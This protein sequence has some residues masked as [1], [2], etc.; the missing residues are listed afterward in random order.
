MSENRETIKQKKDKNRKHIDD[1]AK[2][3]ALNR[4]IASFDFRSDA[5]EKVSNEIFA[6]LRCR[7][8]WESMGLSED[9]PEELT[10]DHLKELVKQKKPRN[11]LVVGAGVSK[12][13]YNIKAADE[14]IEYI[15]ESLGLDKDLRLLSE[16]DKPST[17]FKKDVKELMT[18]LEKIKFGNEGGKPNSTKIESFI[19]SFSKKY[20]D[21]KERLKRLNPSVVSSKSNGKRQKLDEKLDFELNLSL[22]ASHFG[23]RTV[24]EKIREIYDHRYYPCMIYE[25]IAHLLRHRFLDA[26]INFNFDELLDQ[27][28]EEEI[29]GGDH[30]YILSD[31]D[32]G[33]IG[34]LIIK[35]A[36]N[37]PLYIKPHGTVSHKSTM[38]FTKDDYLGISRD[39][40]NFLEEFIS[41]KINSEGDSIGIAKVNIILVGFEMASVE[42]NQIIEKS[43]KHA[44][45]SRDGKK[46]EF[47][48][49]VF[50]YQDVKRGHKAE[51]LRGKIEEEISSRLKLR[52]DPTD[53]FS[54]YTG[55]RFPT[56]KEHFSDLYESTRKLFSQTY[57]PSGIWRKKIVCSL[58]HREDLLPSRM[59]YKPVSI[60]ED[61]KA[62]KRIKK[63]RDQD[64]FKQR[65][66]VEILIELA[67]HKGS[68]HTHKLM[69]GR[70]GLYH[71]LY[72]KVSGSNESLIDFIHSLN[73]TKCNIYSRGVYVDKYIKNFLDPDLTSNYDLKIVDMLLMS[74]QWI[75]MKLKKHCPALVKSSGVD[76]YYL[77]EN[78]FEL[79]KRSNY[80]ISPEY[81]AKRFTL[82]PGFKKD[83]ILNT[84][85]A[86]RTHLNTMLKYDNWDK[87][88]SVG[89]RGNLLFEDL[90]GNQ[91]LAINSNKNDPEKDI[92][93]ILTD[94]IFH[95]SFLKAKIPAKNIGYIPY[96]GRDFCM[97]FTM[98]AMPEKVKRE[99]NEPWIDENKTYPSTLA[100]SGWVV[101]KAI[102]FA[103]NRSSSIITPVFLNFS[104]KLPTPD[105]RNLQR[106]RDFL[107]WIFYEYYEK[108]VRIEG[109]EG[110]RE[111]GQFEAFEFQSKEKLEKGYKKWLDNMFEEQLQDREEVLRREAAW[112]DK[113]DNN[114]N[115]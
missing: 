11:I 109:S 38:R 66:L 105:G 56:L 28:I 61:D 16:L 77:T 15:E 46:R 74:S 49:H 91:K 53:F 35:D 34:D 93:L 1:L 69:T 87:L 31:G 59:G 71:S 42:F 52:E 7:K 102:Y 84:R 101:D 99:L 51:R 85:I 80:A 4:L 78:F 79:L 54:I 76:I 44:R 75:V 8:T 24:R 60:G 103:M 95:Q 20:Q 30:K 90:Y 37:V 58:F 14:A 114:P 9:S 18:I 50:D 65:T 29:Q 88:F 45:R 108:S 47:H 96:Y 62:A 92:Q 113:Y 10:F 39:M 55:Y 27:A 89:T 63:K 100:G 23:V 72:A 3:L 64:Y 25:L 106:D 19:R 13:A 111:F 17:K 82:I 36:M 40:Q 32:C 112:F 41:G 5:T 107:P 21:D 115:C 57:E 83:H 33:D 26:V 86:M 2:D 70:A 81:S 110:N 6:T 12:A 97:T 73:M 104:G 94:N 67:V 43:I 22:I 98:S 48:F 68:V